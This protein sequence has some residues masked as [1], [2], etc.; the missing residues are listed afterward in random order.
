MSDDEKSQDE[1][2]NNDSL[3]NS[4]KFRISGKRGMT[5]HKTKR[6]KYQSKLF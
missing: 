1:S 3:T 6:T 4:R 2:L 5:K